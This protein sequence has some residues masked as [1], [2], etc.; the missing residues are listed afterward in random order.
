MS[1]A[2]CSV[3]LSSAQSGNSCSTWW[4][5]PFIPDAVEAVAGFRLQV[6][7][8]EQAQEQARSQTSV[9]DCVRTQV[10]TTLPSVWQALTLPLMC[11][12]PVF[13]KSFM[14]CWEGAG[15][16]GAYSIIATLHI[17]LLIRCLLGNQGSFS[18]L[19]P[20]EPH[21]GPQEKS[22]F[23]SGTYINVQQHPVCLLW[24]GWICHPGSHT[25]LLT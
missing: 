2:Y 17:P 6:H 10:S 4:I 3:L 1:E 5:R 13:C 18:S 11:W 20:P 16:R 24:Q 8:S 15:S 21:C 25:Y 14:W 19:D 12:A 22:S 9:K 23:K 7:R